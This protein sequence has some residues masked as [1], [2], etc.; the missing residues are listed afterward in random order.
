MIDN[1][2]KVYQGAKVLITGHT[3][4]KG[5]WLALWLS[6]LG[7]RV[8]G[9]SLEPPSKPNFCE[10]VDLLGHLTHIHGDIRDQAYLHKVMA[11]HQPMV[12]FHMAAQSL[13]RPSYQD[14]HL[15]YETNVMG[16]VN[17]LEAVRRT[18]SVR[19]AI[20][21]TS[22]KCYE[23]QEWPWGYRENDP[24]GGHDPYSSSKG[25]AELVTFAYLRSYFSP[26]SSL[27]DRHLALASVRAGNVIGGG[28]WGTD[29]LLPD[30]IRS[31]SRGEEVILRHPQAFR[32]W[33]FVL[34]PLSGYLLLGARLLEEGPKFSGAWNFGPESADI[35][36]VEEV[37]RETIHLW[38][39]GSFRAS[40]PEPFHEAEWLK[41]DSSK[42]RHILGWRHRYS[43][44][45]ALSL[46]LNWYK[47]FYGGAS[48]SG[49]RNL[50]HEQIEEYQRYPH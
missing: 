24:L 32:P 1:L 44:K 31:L 43:L 40:A 22:D 25:C 20:M 26:G 21:V 42:A 27:P 18:D 28:D 33:Q 45:K 5:G 15:T 30:C 2:Q 29:R 6:Q 38:G 3:G 39:Q 23:N 14:P 12:V 4:F 19:A 47:N 34:E 16:T 13:V 48:A 50:S 10:A 7:A 46:A 36:T 41:L 9:Y 17:V 35:W 11:L 49:L 8:V 37:V